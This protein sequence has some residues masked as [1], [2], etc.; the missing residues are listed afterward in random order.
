MNIALLGGT[1]D[2]IHAGHIMVA[3]V[4]RAKLSPAEVIF[5][6]AGNPWTKNINHI[7]SSEHRLA[8]VQLA[9]AGKPGFRVSTIEIE[10]QG[11]TYTVDT[12]R[13]FRNRLTSQDELFFVLGWDNL[14]DL[15][16]WH[17]P[18]ELVLHCRLVAVPRLGHRVPDDKTLEDILPGL[19]KRIIFLDKPEID[20]SASVIR[21][22]VSRGL[23][24]K[25]MVPEAV[26]VYIRDK[27]LYI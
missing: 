23:S 6:P 10:R 4:V 1:F 7:S 19:S 24:L 22:R 20:I 27:G 11:P 18:E 5:I 14:L 16:R 12:V 9:V 21:E 3:E 26:E 25:H 15:P 13:E 8:M 17:R 2:P